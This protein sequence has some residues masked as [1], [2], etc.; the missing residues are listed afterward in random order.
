[1]S[2]IKIVILE[3]NILLG[4]EAEKYILEN[5]NINFK[6]ETHEVDIYEEVK[7]DD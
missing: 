1:M 4:V 3:K 7:K 5:K 2:N 6:I